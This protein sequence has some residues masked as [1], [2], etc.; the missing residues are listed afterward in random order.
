MKWL[1]SRQPMPTPKV[2]Y[3]KA[4]PK[5]SARQSGAPMFKQTAPKLHGRRRESAANR[6]RR[7][8]REQR[9]RAEGVKS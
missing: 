7:K 3:R 1:E 8:R 6:N 5:R 9:Q 4:R 2:P